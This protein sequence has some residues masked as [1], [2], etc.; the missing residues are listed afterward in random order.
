VYVVDVQV[1]DGSL[2]DV[3][4]ISVTVTNLSNISIAVDAAGASEVG[5]TQGSFKLTRDGDLSQSLTV[6]LASPGGTAINGTDYD[7]IGATATFQPNSANA[8]VTITPK[9]DGLV[10]GPETVILS[11]TSNS[12]SQYE[13]AN[14]GT[15]A[16][17]SIADDPAII[18]IGA[19]DPNASESGPDPGSF[20][21]LRSGAMGSSI[22]VT[23]DISGTATNGSDYVG[24]NN[25][26]IPTTIQ[27]A[28]GQTA[29]TIDILPVQDTDPEGDQT[30]AITVLNSGNYSITTASAVVTISDDDNFAPI[31]NPDSVSVDEDH[32]LSI[33]AAD[34]MQNDTP[35]PAS[36]SGQTLE[37]VAVGNGTLGSLGN[38]FLVSGVITFQPAPNRFG[39]A[40]FTYTV[41][42]NGTSNGHAD[43]KSAMGTVTITVNSVNDLPDFTLVG[44]R[45]DVEGASYDAPRDL[46]V[47]GLTL[48]ANDVESGTNL[49]YSVTGLPT[50][51]SVDSTN[52]I[53]GFISYDASNTN[54]GVFTCSVT[55]TDTDGG[56][57]TKS[58][59]WTVTNADLASLT[60]TEV[61]SATHAA[62]GHRATYTD[63][64][65]HMFFVG[66]SSW[67]TPNHV[68]LA[69]AA[70]TGGVLPDANRILFHVTPTSASP[71]DG[72]FATTPEITPDISGAT[73]V[74]VAIDRDH[75][76]NLDASE[77]AQGFHVVIA[78]MS[79]TGAILTSQ[80]TGGIATDPAYEH[81][82]ESQL[83]RVN[84]GEHFEVGG[85]FK[86]A[87]TN[88]SFNPGPNGTRLGYRIYLENGGTDILRQEGTAPGGVIFTTM[89]A[90]DIG[91]LYVQYWVDI[92]GNGA[93]DSSYETL[94][95]PGALNHFEVNTLNRVVLTVAVSD[96]I[97]A[98]Q[99]AGMSQAA[100]HAI[101]DPVVTSSFERALRQDSDDDYRALIAVSVG[102]IT[103]FAA[104]NDPVPYVA[105]G[106]PQPAFG[107]AA[108]DILFF[109]ELVNLRGRVDAISGTKMM[110]DWDDQR[111]HTIVHEYGH[112]MGLL[113]YVGD[114]DNI[115]TKGDDISAAAFK[116][117]DQQV[118]KYE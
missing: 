9:A 94:T 12:Y 26:S 100:L 117:T 105:P 83:F 46:T 30:V 48:G 103:Q 2:T 60:A 65:L 57:T 84:P 1:S 49:T 10:E 82:P 115:M 118:D 113:H 62:I 99:N 3:Q 7:L 4:T 55:V 51:L 15:S 67:N 68:Q 78:K 5:P 52:H 116:L 72:D 90:N 56:S 6:T 18:S 95:A 70:P 40:T 80:R 13:L 108:A 42:D 112:L 59:T 8:W 16:T 69:V 66:V 36:E 29:Y 39:T 54:N 91:E 63:S 81:P 97:P 23:L 111:P 28:P 31:A 88:P 85:K 53:R 61:Y 38:V 76:G 77:M 64:L 87:L 86:F 109:D 89:D 50:G 32:Q 104:T 106:Q 21:I 43:P 74:Y 22:T 14:T 107:D 98:F 25:Q 96:T 73:N 20:T 102:N 71:D 92:D 58:F 19:D 110:I 44:N 37:V 47:E 75:S 114:V 79:L 27:L 34:L 93:F 17:L 45:A 11:L 35:G 101:V 33:S 24:S 41:R